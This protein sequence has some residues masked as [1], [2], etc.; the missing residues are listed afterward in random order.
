MVSLKLI[1]A[2]AP[3]PGRPSS[4]AGDAPRLGV[5][6]PPTVPATPAR[7][8]R[9]YAPRAKRAEGGQGRCCLHDPRAERSH[10]EIPKLKKRANSTLTVKQEPADRMRDPRRLR[11]G[12]GGLASGPKHTT[13]L[14][15]MHTAAHGTRGT[16]RYA[17]TGLSTYSDS[18]RQTRNAGKIVNECIPAFTGNCRN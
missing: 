13:T 11:T 10:G 12:R 9:A 16:V 18:K 6:R 5:G 4:P 8:A 14:T 15:A 17:V 1:L 7:V 2:G 3:G